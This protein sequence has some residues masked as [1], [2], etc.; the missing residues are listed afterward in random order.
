MFFCVMVMEER[1]K[2]FMIEEDETDDPSLIENILARLEEIQS[3]DEN[4]MEV[5]RHF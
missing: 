4:F 3:E 5:E 2:N 1:L